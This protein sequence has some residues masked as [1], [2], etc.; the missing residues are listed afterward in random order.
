MN[1]VYVIAVMTSLGCGLDVLCLRAVEPDS[2]GQHARTYATLDACIVVRDQ[3]MAKDRSD[4]GRERALK[5]VPEDSALSYVKQRH[6][7]A[8]DRVHGHSSALRV[9]GTIHTDSLL[10]MMESPRRS[11]L[12]VLRLANRSALDG[13]NKLYFSFTHSGVTPY[14]FFRRVS[15]RS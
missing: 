11:D 7:A 2:S 1:T 9:S 15:P 8:H 6:A 4:T 3:L 13:R 5:C 14:C 10:Y 12:V